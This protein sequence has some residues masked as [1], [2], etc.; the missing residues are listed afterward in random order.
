MDHKQLVV[1]KI[2]EFSPLGETIQFDYNDVFQIRWSGSTTNSISVDIHH[3]LPYTVLKKP[4]ME[5]KAV[6]MF[7]NV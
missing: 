3:Q 4:D 1:S 2:L 5:I 6:N 7:W